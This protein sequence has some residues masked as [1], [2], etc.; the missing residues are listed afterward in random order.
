MYSD[1]V[2]NPTKQ[3]AVPYSIRG[4]G[5]TRTRSIFIASHSISRPIRVHIRRVFTF[6]ELFTHSY[7]SRI[8]ARTHHHTQIHS[9]IRVQFI[10]THDYSNRHYSPNA[11]SFIITRFFI[12]DS[13]L[14]ASLWLVA[15]H[16]NSKLRCPSLTW[17]LQIAFIIQFN[18]FVLR[19]IPQFYFFSLFTSRFAPWQ[20]SRHQV[21]ITRKMVCPYRIRPVAGSIG[22]TIL[23]CC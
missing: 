17:L 15:F 21:S 5:G 20:L 3:N 9:S 2:H 10:V 7:C 19:L 16:D 6:K 18:S 22:S 1:S 13:I 23:N 14:R 12:P 11:Y 8:H 4:R